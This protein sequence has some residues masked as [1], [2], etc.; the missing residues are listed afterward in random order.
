ME[1]TGQAA[2]SGDQQSRQRAPLSDAAAYDG[3]SYCIAD[4]RRF[5]TG[6]LTGLQAVHGFPV[7]AGRW[8]RRSWW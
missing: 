8:E 4:A 6:Y 2:D 5:A 7:S 3:Q 1:P